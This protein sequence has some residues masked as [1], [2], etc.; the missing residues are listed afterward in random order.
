MVEQR[1]FR[2]YAGTNPYLFASYSHK[3]SG[4]V[5]AVLEQLFLKGYNVWYD[6]GIPNNAILDREISGKIK[7][8]EVFVLFLSANSVR[9]EYVMDKELPLAAKK[10]KRV[11]YVCLD[12]GDYQT[13][14]GRGTV[15][16]ADEIE[17]LLALLPDSC[18]ECE[19]REPAPIEVDLSEGIRLMSDELSGFSYVI[20]Q[21]QLFINEFTLTKELEKEI[22]EKGLLDI[23]I[24]EQH[25]GFPV[26]GILPSTFEDTNPDAGEIHSVTL[27]DTMES[28]GEAA[29]SGSRIEEVILPQTLKRI[30]DDCFSESNDL[31]HIEL[32]YGLETIEAC[33]FWQCESLEEI[34]IPETVKSIGSQ[35]FESYSAMRFAVIAPG[36]TFLD[37]AVFDYLDSTD[38]Y[39]E[40]ELEE[41]DLD[42]VFHIICVEGSAAHKYAKQNHLFTKLISEKEMEA[43]Y[44]A[45]LRRKRDEHL[46]AVKERN[47]AY[48]LE[49][50]EKAEGPYGC[51]VIGREDRPLLYD[52]ILQLGADGYRLRFSD[53]MDSPAAKDSATLLPILSSR[54]VGDDGYVRAIAGSKKSLFPLMLDNSPVPKELANRFILHLSDRTEKDL[55]NEIREHLSAHACRGNPRGEEAVRSQYVDASFDYE[56]SSETYEGDKNHL[57][58]T[59]YKKNE[60]KVI[61]PDELFGYPVLAIGRGLFKDHSE[62]ESVVIGAHVRFI[63]KEAFSGCRSL[64][65]VVIPGSVERIQGRAFADCVS[66]KEIKLPTAIQFLAEDVFAGCAGDLVIRAE[67]GSKAEEIARKNGLSV[68]LPESSRPKEGFWARLFRRKADN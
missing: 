37:E 24:P 20:S 11:L 4:K 50:M 60:T 10:K 36:T 40:D 3:D 27:P 58:L 29:F 14:C 57:V 45:P 28:I 43:R 61:V 17:K 47:I 46:A 52:L 18:R 38:E 44:Q 30:D 54:N 12:E 8:C 22:E 1:P 56:F 68:A 21:G 23:V 15:V 53:K 5:Y 55:L 41:V 42:E 32:P 67:K 13:V 31:S 59:A 51:I 35:A 26:K 34:V 48:I 39:D 2:A 7:E 33:A 25:A 66:L 9:S 65:E 19:K 49:D 16:R 63:G 62:I 64:K 6:Q